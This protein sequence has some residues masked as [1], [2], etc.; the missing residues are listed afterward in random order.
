[1]KCAYITIKLKEIKCT[2][3]KII[4]PNEIKSTYIKII[5]LYEKNV[6]NLKLLSSIK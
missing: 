4:D 6:R 3:I 1:M 2:Y 5:E